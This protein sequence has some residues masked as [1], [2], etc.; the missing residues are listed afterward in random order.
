[1]FVTVALM[2]KRSLPALIVPG[3]PVTSIVHEKSVSGSRFAMA[4]VGDCCSPVAFGCC[5]VHPE[6][7]MTPVVNISAAAIFIG[8]LYVH[9]S[10]VTT[11]TAGGHVR[12]GAR[13][14]HQQSSEADGSS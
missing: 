1:M 2:P 6:A 7:T 8:R 9:P 13:R 5:P 11:G 10:R 12:A 4:A 3:T 14:Q